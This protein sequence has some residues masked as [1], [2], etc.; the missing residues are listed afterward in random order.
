MTT[1]DAPAHFAGAC[2][3][4][5]GGNAEGAAFRAAA[6]DMVAASSKFATAGADLL[7]AT[8]NLVV[9]GVPGPVRHPRWKPRMQIYS[10]IPPYRPPAPE[11]KFHQYIEAKGKE[12]AKLREALLAIAVL[13]N[14]TW[15]RPTTSAGMMRPVVAELRDM[16][17]EAAGFTLAEIA[18]LRARA[19]A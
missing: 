13:A 19:Q 15:E 3:A 7:A 12:V 10:K 17:A 9:V 18:E 14:D 8:S 6:A 2:A 16:A 11:D 5:A 1:A 4:L